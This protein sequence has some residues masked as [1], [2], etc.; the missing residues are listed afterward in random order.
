MQGR[1]PLLG[2]VGLKS[3][4]FL[5]SFSL[6]AVDQ[7]PLSAPF[8]VAPPIQAREP[9]CSDLLFCDQPENTL[10]GGRLRVGL[11]LPDNLCISRSAAQE[12][13]WYLQDLSCP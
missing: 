10:L 9:R 7:R 5:S 8:P 13:E 11:G 4:C 2:A 12:L 3:P 6:L 1:I